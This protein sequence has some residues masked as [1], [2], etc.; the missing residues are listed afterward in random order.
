MLDKTEKKVERGVGRRRDGRERKVSGNWV[1]GW[2]GVGGCVGGMGRGRLIVGCVGCLGGAEWRIREG[3]AKG[4]GAGVGSRAK[5]EVGKENEEA[6]W[7]DEGMEEEEIKV[8]EKVGD[9]PGLMAEAGLAEGEKPPDRVE[10]VD[11][12]L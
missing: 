8:G 2:G 1:V 4:I 7:E 3:E 12:I 9:V 6:D 10:D 5:E 11:E